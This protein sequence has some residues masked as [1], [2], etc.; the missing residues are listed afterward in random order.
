MVDDAT[1][2]RQPSIS[3]LQGW[4]DSRKKHVAEQIEQWQQREAARQALETTNGKGRGRMSVE[5][6]Q[7]RKERLQRKTREGMAASTDEILIIAE[8]TSESVSQPQS[9]YTVRIPSTSLTHSWYQPCHYETLA[10][11]KQAGIWH[12]PSTLEERASC[13]VFRDL[14][15]KGH[16]LGS[17]IKFGGK[18]LVYPGRAY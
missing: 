2:T 11:A 4:D 15:E 18:F 14:W 10:S 16:F 17:G 7:K 5:A 6:V 1:A 13:H 8:P 12:F 3:E 9:T